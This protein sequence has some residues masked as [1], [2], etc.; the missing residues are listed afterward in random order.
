MIKFEKTNYNYL[1]RMLLSPP[2]YSICSKTRGGQ[3]CIFDVFLT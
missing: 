2:P 1:S 3:Q